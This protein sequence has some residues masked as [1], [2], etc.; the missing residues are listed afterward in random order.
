MR[1]TIPL[2]DQGF[3]AAV[4]LSIKPIQIAGCSALQRQEMGMG[5]NCPENRC[6]GASTPS[7]RARW[8]MWA[9]DLSAA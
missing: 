1:R 5:R 8:F 2:S 3:P 6:F 9:L 4:E 7:I